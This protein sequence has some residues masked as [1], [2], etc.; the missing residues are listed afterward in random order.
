MRRTIGVIIDTMDGQYQTIVS[1]GLIKEA[2]KKD[3][4]LLFFSGVPLKSTLSKDAQYNTIFHL[5]NKDEI[6]GIIL[7][8]SS[9]ENHTGEEGVE[10]LSGMFTGM[11]TVSISIPVENA[12]NVMLD[13]KASMKLVLDHVLTHVDVDDIAYISGPLKNVEAICRMEAYE[14]MLKDHNRE[15]R[16]SHFYEG[17]FQQ[18]AGQKAVDYFHSNNI[19]M[20]RA[21]VAANDEM[22]IGAYLRLNELGIQVPGDVLLTGFDNID[23]AQDFF[24]PFTTF[25]QHSLNMSKIAIDKIGDLIDGTIEPGRYLTVGNLIIRESCGCSVLSDELLEIGSTN[26]V[27]GNMDYNTALSSFSDYLNQN[28]KFFEQMIIESIAS[29]VQDSNPYRQYTRQLLKALLDDLDKHIVD[30]QFIKSL[31]QMANHAI[32]NNNLNCQLQEVVMKLRASTVAHIFNR[33]LI[34]QLQ[35]IYFMADAVMGESMRRKERHH[36]FHF[37]RMYLMSRDLVQEL[38]LAKSIDEIVRIVKLSLPLYGINQCYMC[39]YDDPVEYDAEHYFVYPRQTRL[40]MGYNEGHFLKQRNFNTSNMLPDEV[41]GQENR[42][43]FLFHALFDDTIQYGYIVFSVDAIDPLIY[44]TL[45]AQISA[46]L[47]RRRNEEKRIYAEYTL[48]SVLKELELSNDLLRAQ[49][50]RDELTG[51]LNRR[52]FYSEAEQYYNQAIKTKEPFYALFGDIDGLKQINDVYGHDEGDFAIKKIAYT[53]SNKIGQS[54]I[55]ARMS[56][57]EFTALILNAESEEI[58]RDYLKAI[59]EELDDFNSSGIKPYALSVSLGYAAY[60]YVKLD[61]MDALLKHADKNLYREKSRRKKVT[62]DD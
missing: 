2:V 6:D 44:E 38:N 16:S 10:R 36:Q 23:A 42:Y 24:P 22:A 47:K 51:L 5:P 37:R 11:P 43:D 35:D 61:T 53:I 41:L 40:E 13:N 59:Q 46:A 4:N 8:L 54:N 50:V 52:G 25:D 34:Q 14:D 18:S 49:S 60:D 57:D 12:L 31:N 20:P 1:E 21:I 48:H 17:N 15:I 58:M 28:I 9:L 55:V 19:D 27:V 7:V 29:Y 62:K 45:R 3:Y 32:I 56:G 30:G 39:V 33:T 26:L